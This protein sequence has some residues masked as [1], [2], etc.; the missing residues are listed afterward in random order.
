MK[1][2]GSITRNKKKKT[3]KILVLAK[4]SLNSIENLES[5]ALI[6]MEISHEQF[7]K[8]LDEKE[9]YEQIKKN[10]R[11]MKSSDEAKKN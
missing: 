11:T 7:I 1:K 6:D 9:K 3:I 8:T 4:G 10:I 5:E 2:L